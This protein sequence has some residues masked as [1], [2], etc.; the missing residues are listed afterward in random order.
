VTA[1]EKAADK[2]ERRL[3]QAIPLPQTMYLIKVKSGAP[4]VLAR[5]VAHRVEIRSY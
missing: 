3:V 4:M 1:A 5:A 2:G